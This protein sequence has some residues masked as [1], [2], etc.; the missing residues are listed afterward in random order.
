L[1]GTEPV[2]AVECFIALGSNL[3]DRAASLQ[4]AVRELKQTEGIAVRDASP[5][6]ETDPIGQLPQGPYLNAVLKVETVLGPL[7][8]LGRMQQIERAAGRVR[9]AERNGPR[10]LDL[11]LL[12]YGQQCLEIP[13]LSVP[14]PRLHERAFVLEPLAELAPAF[15]HPLLGVSIAQ[16]AARVRDPA[17]VRSTSIGLEGI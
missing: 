1:S 7:E 10:S 4:R 8:L 9:T 16:L 12:F 5:V 17:S 15:R 14:H 6:Y 11:D 3:G 13:E 2:A